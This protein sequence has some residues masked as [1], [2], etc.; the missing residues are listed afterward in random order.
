MWGKSKGRDDKGRDDADLL[1]SMG[2]SL[3]MNIEV[4]QEVNGRWIAEVPALPGALVYGTSLEEAIRK[5]E[6]LVLRVIAELR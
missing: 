3:D 6:V 4:E 5:V 2:Y 1:G